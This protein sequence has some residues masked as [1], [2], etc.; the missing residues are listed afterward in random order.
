MYVYKYAITLTP[1]IKVSAS[2]GIS[3]SCWSHRELDCPVTNSITI[4]V[5]NSITNAVITSVTNWM[6]ISVANWLPGLKSFNGLSNHCLYFQMRPWVFK[7]SRE[8]SKEA[9]GFQSKPW[10]FKPAVVPEPAS[11]IQHRALKSS[12]WAL[13]WGP[14]LLLEAPGC[15]ITPWAFEWSR[16]FKCGLS[17]DAEDYQMTPRDV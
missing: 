9:L 6:I 12:A 5:T 10:A 4:S 14:R 17:N 2:L 13:N 11:P 15:Q 7:R 3:W 1:S 16:R 8:L